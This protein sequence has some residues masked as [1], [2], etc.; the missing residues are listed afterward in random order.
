MVTNKGS[1]RRVVVAFIVG[2]VIS[3]SVPH[4]TAASKS[5]AVDGAQTCLYAG[6][7]IKLGDVVRVDDQIYIR[8]VPDVK[9][10]RF[11]PVEVLSADDLIAS[12]KPVKTR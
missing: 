6:H 9:W 1:W 11:E 4:F 7:T 12:A 3:L 10:A 2:A 8:C 5:T